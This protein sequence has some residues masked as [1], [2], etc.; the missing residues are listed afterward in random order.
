M[1]FICSEANFRIADP[2]MLTT[3]GSVKSNSN[4]S[5]FLW[6][7]MIL[8]LCVIIVYICLGALTYSIWKKTSFADGAYLCFLTLTT[9][10]SCDMLKNVFNPST[11]T[12]ELVFYCL[13]LFIGLALTSA[14]L[15]LIQRNINRTGSYLILT[16]R[17]KN[18][19]EVAL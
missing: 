19:E 13:Y 1:R 5:A 2:R 12:S 7:P 4:E 10:G 6:F 3:S 18:D 8:A 15:Y 17:R 11:R 14:F 9:I 16:S